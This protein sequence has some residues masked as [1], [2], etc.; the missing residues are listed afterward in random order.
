VCGRFEWSVWN[1]SPG[2]IRL[3][4]YDLLVGD[5]FDLGMA[6]DVALLFVVRF[7]DLVNKGNRF[8]FTIAVVW[9]SADND[10]REGLYA[11]GP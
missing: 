9:T 5:V 4:V 6:G 3:P 8:L 1:V 10:F 7:I 2:M 11:E